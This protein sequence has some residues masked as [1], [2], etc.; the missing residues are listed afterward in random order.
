MSPGTLKPTRPL[1][2][3]DWRRGRVSYIKVIIALGCEDADI[4]N[5]VASARLN[6]PDRAPL[7]VARIAPDGK[8]YETAW[9]AGIAT[10]ILSDAL[11]PA[12]GYLTGR[13]I[14]LLAT[15]RREDLVPLH[16]VWA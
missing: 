2:V 12:L 9:R 6:I 5:R 3:V 8:G 11:L 15:L 14:G 1:V 4:R 10:G 7:P 16:G 13:R